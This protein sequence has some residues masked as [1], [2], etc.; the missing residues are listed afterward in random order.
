MQ[1]L[2][3]DA[4]TAAKWQLSEEPEAEQARG[5]LQDY[6]AEQVALIAPKIWHYEIANV[7]NKAVS[8]RRLTEAEGQQAFNA[9]QALDI[10]FVA[11]PSP[12]AAYR[13]AR[14]Y[15]RSVYDSLYLAAAQARGID[16]WTGDR[17]L[18]NAVKNRLSFVR[19]IGDYPGVESENRT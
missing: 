15:Q 7:L 3:I 6:A 9:L 5:M 13:L 14:T 19:W 1:K 17:R 16:L 12:S 18:H 2:A 11:W 4:S 10:E 8:T